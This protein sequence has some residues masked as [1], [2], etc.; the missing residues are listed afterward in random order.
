[1]FFVD[2][3]CSRAQDHNATSRRCSATGKKPSGCELSP[4]PM[5]KHQPKT[6]PPT[7]DTTGVQDRLWSLQ[8][9]KS[10]TSS[11]YPA[12]SLPND[13][14]IGPLQYTW[15]TPIQTTT[16]PFAVNNTAI[17]PRVVA[18]SSVC[19]SEFNSP[20]NQPSRR[21]VHHDSALA[22]RSCRVGSSPRLFY[23]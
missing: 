4:A 12:V 16:K 11:R 22:S 5:D 15:T 14:S 20:D 17:R 21:R 7:S 10:T 13:G 6:R 23:N 9:L 19:S 2:V 8:L 18:K 1:M 3:A